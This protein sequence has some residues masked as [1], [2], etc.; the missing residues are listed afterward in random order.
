MTESTAR[1]DQNK[2]MK[3][4]SPIGTATNQFIR[5]LL[6]RGKINDVIAVNITGGT[7]LQLNA[8]NHDMNQLQI[9]KKEIYFMFSIDF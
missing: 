5:V 7:L 1:D 9:E 3:A 4:H 6:L 8:S 2:P